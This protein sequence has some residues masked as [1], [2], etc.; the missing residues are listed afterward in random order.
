MKEGIPL[1]FGSIKPQGDFPGSSESEES[2]CSAGDQ[3]LGLRVG[4]IP[5]GGNGNP[6]QYY[7][8]ENSMDRGGNV[9]GVAK[10]WALSHFQKGNSR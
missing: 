8:L 6:L 1:P 9:H 2:A 3:G 7:C 5:G 4:K 10:S